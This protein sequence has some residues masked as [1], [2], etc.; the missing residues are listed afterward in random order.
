MTSE[1]QPG[2]AEDKPGSG[3]EHRRHLS[4]SSA[5]GF[6][7]P[8]R[9]LQLNSFRIIHAQQ[10]LCKHT[11]INVKDVTGHCGPGRQEKSFY[12]GQQGTGTCLSQSPSLHDMTQVIVSIIGERVYLNGEQVFDR[13]EC[14]A[15]GG[16][17]V[18]HA[19]RGAQ[20][21]PDAV[22]PGR[23]RAAARGANLNQTLQL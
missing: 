18:P 11:T 1:L 9:G 6:S 4:A 19:R 21:G 5:M 16:R 17:A 2:C 22:H 3:K 12:T 7:A 14:G 13:G 23:E 10:G 15:A 8:S 20:A